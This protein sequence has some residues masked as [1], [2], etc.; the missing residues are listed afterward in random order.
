MYVG[1]KYRL[2]ARAH[3]G[4]RSNLFTQLFGGV[5]VPKT[6]ACSIID[7]NVKVTWWVALRK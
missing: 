7:R 4:V 2:V 6:Y 5:L 3:R 1:R